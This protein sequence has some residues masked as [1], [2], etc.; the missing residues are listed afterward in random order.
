MR[1]IDARALKGC[2]CQNVGAS[3]EQ[4][5]CVT[6][7][8]VNTRANVQWDTARHVVKIIT[9]CYNRILTQLH[10]GYLAPIKIQPL[11]HLRPFHQHD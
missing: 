9:R 6:A 8:C 11:T 4:I 7:A 1:F 5:N 3:R 10:Q 2:R